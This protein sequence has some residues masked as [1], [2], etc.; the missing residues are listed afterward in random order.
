M[1]APVELEYVN[2]ANSAEDGHFA[3]GRNP[4]TYPDPAIVNPSSD[5]ADIYVLTAV[6]DDDR[7]ERRTL[8]LWDFSELSGPVQAVEMRA[9]L[10][11]A[12]RHRVD[13]PT[14]EAFV[15]QG[16]CLSWPYDACFDDINPAGSWGD[17]SGNGNI[18]DPA[19]D[20]QDLIDDAA[21]K[22]GAFGPHADSNI[23][24][25]LEPDA[26]EYSWTFTD[27]DWCADAA[28]AAAGIVLAFRQVYPS[29][30]AT[31]EFSLAGLDPSNRI[32]WRD[33]RLFVSA[34]EAPDLIEL[35]AVGQFQLSGYGRIQATGRDDRTYHRA[36]NTRD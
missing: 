20:L 26:P 25:F 11:T 32:N 12:A 30:V 24:E 8:V 36:L 4:F 16:S 13:I 27:P 1:P 7:W 2:A 28:G 15:Y 18:L 17:L 35:K 23:I 34:G 3:V 6:D 9:N 5:E 14:F 31:G 19:W 21:T 29:P 33:V 10:L 22:P